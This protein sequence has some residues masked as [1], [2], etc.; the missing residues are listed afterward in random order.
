MPAAPRAVT[1]SFSD[2][3]DTG[4]LRT[5]ALEPARDHPDASSPK[6]EGCRWNAEDD[7]AESGHEDRGLADLDLLVSVPEPGDELRDEVG[8]VGDRDDARHEAEGDPETGRSGDAGHDQQH[9]ARK[10]PRTDAGL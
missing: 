7:Q 8:E 3:V 1:T 9:E 6:G 10:D 4:R 2:S 5:V